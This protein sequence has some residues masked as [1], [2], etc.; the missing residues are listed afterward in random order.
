MIEDYNMAY[1]EQSELPAL[2]EDKVAELAKPRAVCLHDGDGFIA[3]RGKGYA[4]TCIEKL[5]DACRRTT[6][7]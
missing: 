3:S 4:H 5:R 6:C 1:W 2:D 7:A